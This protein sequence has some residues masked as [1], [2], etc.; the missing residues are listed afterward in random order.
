MNNESNKRPELILQGDRV[1]TLS[2]GD[3]SLALRRA[4]V[5]SEFT[6]VGEAYVHAVMNGEP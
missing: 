4:A 5:K 6:L 3:V 1:Y 2:G